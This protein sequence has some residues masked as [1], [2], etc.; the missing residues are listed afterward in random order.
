M[1]LVA[2]AVCSTGKGPALFRQKCYGFNNELI[3]ALQV[4]LHVRGELRRHGLQA[5][6]Q[7]RSARHVCRRYLARPASMSCRHSTR[8]GANVARGSAPRPRRRKAGHDLYENVVQD[9]SRATASRPRDGW[10][11]GQRLAVPPTPRTRSSAAS[12]AI[13]TRSL[14]GR[15]RS[16]SLRS[17]PFPWS[18]PR[19]PMK[20]PSCCV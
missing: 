8:A 11:A 13:S 17:H 4:P 5:R 16:A 6:H 9:V 10:G 3:E 12:S 7:G 1:A 20:R 14:V 2:I 18:R 19:M 15:L